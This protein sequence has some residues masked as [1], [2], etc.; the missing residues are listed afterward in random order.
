MTK[1]QRA[2]GRRHGRSRMQLLPKQEQDVNGKFTVSLTNETAIESASRRALQPKR[3]S[4]QP[5]FQWALPEPADPAGLPMA[6]AI[7]SFAQGG[8]PV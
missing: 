5:I 3:G 2:H 7:R 8:R 6:P 4:R 1:G